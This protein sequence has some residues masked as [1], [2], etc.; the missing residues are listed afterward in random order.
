MF[1]KIASIVHEN[2][3]PGGGLSRERN[4]GYRKAKSHTFPALASGK[5]STPSRPLISA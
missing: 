3:A 4:E 2:E 5:T 1:V